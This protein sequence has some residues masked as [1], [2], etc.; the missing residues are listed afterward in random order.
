MLVGTDDHEEGVGE[1]GQGGPARPQGEAADLVLAW[2]SV[3]VRYREP[4]TLFPEILENVTQ[5]ELYLT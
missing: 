4:L 5:L 3:S 2:K 1:R